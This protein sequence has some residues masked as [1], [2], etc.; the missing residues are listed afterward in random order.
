M[1]VLHAGH[2]FVGRRGLLGARLDSPVLRYDVPLLALLH[3]HRVRRLR[4]SLLVRFF[5]ALSIR[6]YLP[7][8][9]RWLMSQ[10]RFDEVKRIM[11][12]CATFNGKELP[13]HLLPHLEVRVSR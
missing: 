10:G 9:P 1:L 5:H 11:K 3:S 13:E 12:N 4:F 8:S 2:A 7:E 6:S